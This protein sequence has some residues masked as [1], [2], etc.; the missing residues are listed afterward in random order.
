MNTILY[1]LSDTARFLRRDFDARVR[2]LGM[3]SAQARLLLLLRRTE[4]ENQAFYADQLEVEPITLTR[5]IDRMEETSLIERRRD[6]DDR[7]AW[8]LHLTARSHQVIDEVGAVLKSLEDE[9]LA[10][11][12]EAQHGALRTALEQIRDNFS[13][14]VAVKEVAHG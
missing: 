3:T 7:R 6:P 1:L 9:M 13:T 4:G 10:G 8:R 12:D 2:E 5:M 14:S 11:L